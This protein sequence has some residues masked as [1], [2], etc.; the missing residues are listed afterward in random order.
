MSWIAQET[1]LLNDQILL[2]SLA[3][4]L[5]SNFLKVD[6]FLIVCFILHGAGRVRIKFLEICVKYS[7]IH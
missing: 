2:F 4:Q 7:A 5:R 1:Y 6:D 3:N